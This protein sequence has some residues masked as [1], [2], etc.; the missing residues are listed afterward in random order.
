MVK[1]PLAKAGDAGSIPGSGGSPG[2][3]NSNPL[4]YSS[5]GNS[6]DRGA[7]Q[8]TVLELAKELDE[9]HHIENIRTTLVILHLYSVIYFTY[10][11]QYRAIA[12]FL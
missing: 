10:S 4:Q 12:C 2:E 11:S 8:A 3:G 5:L 7:C 9:A 1:N 6:M